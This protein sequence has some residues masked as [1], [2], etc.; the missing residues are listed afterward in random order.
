MNKRKILYRGL[1][2]CKLNAYE[3]NF[4][5]DLSLHPNTNLSQ[6][7]SDYLERI[8]IRIGK[9]NVKVGIEKEINRI[10]LQKLYSYLD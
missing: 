10:K 1:L 8:I 2:F 6:K 7:Q 9:E 5:I 3:K 4:I